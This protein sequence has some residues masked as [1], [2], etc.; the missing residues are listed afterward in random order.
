[1]GPTPEVKATFTE[2]GDTTW[3]WVGSKIEEVGSNYET[4]GLHLEGPLVWLV[5]P[6]VQQAGL[7][8]QRGGHWC[9]WWDPRWRLILLI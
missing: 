4:V 6:L 3:L 9:S 7:L 2:V 1:M 8:L 5:G